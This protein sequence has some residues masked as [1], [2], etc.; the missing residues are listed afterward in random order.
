VVTLILT[1]SLF[2]LT[3]EAKARILGRFGAN[4]PENDDSDDAETADE[5]PV[6]AH[7]Q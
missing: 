6:A 3:L 5:T 7:Y 4:R 2:T 1:P